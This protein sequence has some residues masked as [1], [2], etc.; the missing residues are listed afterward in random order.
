MARQESSCFANKVAVV[1]GAGS[2]LGAAFARSLAAQG[3]HVIVADL[4]RVKAAQIADEIG[5]EGVQVDVADT[6]QIASLLRAVRSR[7]GSLDLLINNAGISVG[8]DP[9]EIPIEQWQ[10]VLDVNLMG[11]IAGSLAALR[12]MAE[13]GSGQI[14]NMCSMSGLALLP[15]FGPYSASKAGA[16][17]FSRG[18]AEEARAYGVQ[19]ALACPGRIRTSLLNAGGN[20]L[21]APMEPDYAARR[22]LLELRRGRRI[23]VFPFSANLW[24]WLE[25]LSPALLGPLRQGVVKRARARQAAATQTAA[26]QAAV[27]HSQ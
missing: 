19:V 24:W 17:M 21:M 8:G 14:L 5:A 2:G 4:S 7:Y 18:L 10:R 11:V 15:M 27:I 13:Q 12:I 6:D 26:T 16:V 1:T 22:I 9:L 25:R 23:I 3:A 20:R